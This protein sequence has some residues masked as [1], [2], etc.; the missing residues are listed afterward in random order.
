MGEKRLRLG[1]LFRRSRPYTA[2]RTE[3]SDSAAT[4]QPEPTLTLADIDASTGK[5]PGADLSD[6]TFHPSTED[7]IAAIMAHPYELDSYT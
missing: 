5:G 3:K 2:T 1:R 6:C 7:F 4:P